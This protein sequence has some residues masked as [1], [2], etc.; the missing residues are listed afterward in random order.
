MVAW[1]GTMAHST[2]LVVAALAASMLAAAGIARS[3]AALAAEP[4]TAAAYARAVTRICAGA[5]LFDHHHEVG[6]RS[7]ALSVARDIRRST[8]RRLALV[9]EVTPPT[10]ERRAAMRWIVLEQR[11]ANEYAR[12]WVRI[13]DVIDAVRT[14]RQRARQPQELERLVHASDP[15]RRIVTVLELRLH[16]PDCTGGVPGRPSGGSQELGALVG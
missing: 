16:V 9:S 4:P 10:L 8:R 15:L 5:L 11:L 14:P 6:T 2:R 7:G 3:S 12:D 13:F 1:E